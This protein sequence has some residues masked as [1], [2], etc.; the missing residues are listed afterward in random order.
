M[1]L[2]LLIQKVKYRKKHLIACDMDMTIINV[3]TINLINDNL[4]QNS[5]ISNIT[6]KAMSGSINFKKSIIAR[7]KLLKGIHKKDIKRHNMAFNWR[8]KLQFNLP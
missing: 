7:T 3:E 5:Q 6:E 1:Y 4:L 8:R 2:D